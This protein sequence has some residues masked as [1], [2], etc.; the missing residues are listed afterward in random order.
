MFHTFMELMKRSYPLNNRGVPVGKHMYQH[1]KYK[2][3]QFGMW[4]IFVA[5]SVLFYIKQDLPHKF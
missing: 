4:E 2:A 3:L 1:L 5:I